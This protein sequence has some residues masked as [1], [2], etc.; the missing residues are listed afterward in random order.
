MVVRTA[1]RRSIVWPA[2]LILW[3]MIAG[4]CGGE[5]SS[6]THQRVELGGQEFELELAIDPASRFRGLSDREGIDEDGGMLFV[7]PRAQPLTFVMRRCRVPIDLIL[8]GP[9]GRIVAMHAMEV[10]PYETPEHRLK[11]YASHWPSQFAIEIEG[12]MA[13]TL[14]LALG[15]KVDLPLEALKRRAR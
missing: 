14:G 4:G 1:H 12:G 7:F 5:A 11:R 8:L 6:P 13:A 15:Q 3:V 2:C 9:G 10:E